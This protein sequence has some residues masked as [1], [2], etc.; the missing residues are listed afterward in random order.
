M[1]F[2]RST[3]EIPVI[4][5]RA[6]TEIVKFVLKTSV[7]FLRILSPKMVRKYF[8]SFFVCKRRGVI[9]SRTYWIVYDSGIISN[10][11]FWHVTYLF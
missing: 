11:C 1:V 6:S 7:F 3:A 5:S 9:W 4:V 10:I 2:A 8:A